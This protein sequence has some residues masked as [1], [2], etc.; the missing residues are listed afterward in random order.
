MST[1]LEKLFSRTPGQR[2]GAFGALL[3][4]LIVVPLAVAGLFAAALATA[5]QRVD[6]LPAIVVNND[7]IVTSTLP[8]GT[9]QPVLAGRMLVTELTKPSGDGS[10]A[11]GFAWTISNSTDAAAALAS[12][13][14]YAVLTIPEDFSASVTS[15]GG[16]TPTQ[17]D[18]GI[19]TD[20]AHSFLAGSVA[21][22]VGTAM[23]GVF[24][25]E[26]TSQYLNGLYTN[27]AV[28]GES[29][30]Q[31]ADGAAQVSTGVT[32]VATGLESLAGGTAAAASGASSAATGAASFS[33]GVTEYT[34]GVT[35]LSDGLTRLQAGAAG[36]APL[37]TGLPAYAAGVQDSA[38]GFRQLN[39]LMQSDSRVADYAPALQ[40]LQGGL[41]A[42]AAQSPGIGQAG[43]GIEGV[44]GGLSQSADGASQ[45]AAGG[46]DLR[47]GAS[48]LAAGVAGV[49][50]GLSQLATG[51]TDAAAGARLLE[52]GAAELAGGLQEGADSAAPLTDTDPEATAAV[53]SEPVGITVERDNAFAS[54]GPVIG[55]VFVPIG[56]WIGALAIFLVMKPLSA[57][58]LAS[59]AST[60]GLVVRSLGRA[61]GIAAAQAV[62]VVLLL[63]STLGVSWSIL[64]STLAFAVF[65]A[66]VF[67]AL[68]HFLTAAFG[69]VGIVVS[70]VLLALQ[71]TAVGGLYPIELVSAP[72]QMIS[73][74]LP[75]TWAVQGM[76]AIVSGGGT[77]AGG[78]AAILVIFA[79]VSV[80]ASYGTVASRRGARSFGLAQARS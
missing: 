33:S 61:F 24:G 80:L 75:L 72:F 68:H 12:G 23:S 3:A 21:Q 69:R 59:T 39:A 38:D 65:L 41:D 62:V 45:L 44:L 35:G 25:R 19:R 71:L 10:N 7:E 11:T 55:M 58:A 47:G 48:D 36:L 27:L 34:Q 13:D 28:L 79:V 57:I 53:V 8:D 31:A 74:F 9:E 37:A 16:A 60:G 70:L 15:L 49:S 56:L 18:L 42:L 54:I 29:L 78:P 5:D 73:P 30:T 14:A 26:I 32:G 77:S 76:Q 63:H 20:D 50:T 17:A 1:R 67:A 2:R 43:P 6:T 66:F 64:P 22:S 51:T 46:G 40:Q 52:S 4:G